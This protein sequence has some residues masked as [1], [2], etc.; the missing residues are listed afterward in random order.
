MTAEL[1][2]LSLT[3]LSGYALL[4]EGVCEKELAG[5][6]CDLWLGPQKFH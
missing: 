1:L 4:D 2:T 5:L 6:P 3:L